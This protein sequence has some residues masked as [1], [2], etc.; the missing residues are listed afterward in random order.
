MLGSLKD[1]LDP[2]T[3]DCEHTDSVNMNLDF[4]PSETR[5]ALSNPIERVT[6]SAIR[7]PGDQTVVQKGSPAA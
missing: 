4:C 3:F 2:L 6:A 7:R 5:P 1:Q